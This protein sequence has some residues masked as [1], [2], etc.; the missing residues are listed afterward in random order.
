V[1]QDI[2]GLSE[3]TSFIKAFFGKD[4]E[5]T[6]SPFY[7]HLIR[8]R[9]TARSLRFLDREIQAAGQANGGG[10]YPIPLPERFENWPSLSQAQ[11]L[12]IET[13]LHPYLL[14]SQGDRMGMANSV[15]GRFPFLDHRVVEF[16]NSLPPAFK[17]LGLQEKWLLRKLA[18]EYLPAEIWKRTKRP[19]RA[20]IHKAFFPESGFDEYVGDLLS[21]RSLRQSG[22]FNPQSVEML[23]RKAS[24]AGRLSEVDEMA[25]VGILSTQIVHQLFIDR[26]HPGLTDLDQDNV[27]VVNRNKYS[28]RE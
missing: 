25:L 21:T 28:V 12:E 4:L 9:N 13:F 24:K 23:M 1:Y 17:Q 10:R 2:P 3:N 19:Y 14:S 11:Y 27:K 15:E 26:Q 20:P 16:A 22:Y 18:Q 7:S 8:W 5:E 6:D